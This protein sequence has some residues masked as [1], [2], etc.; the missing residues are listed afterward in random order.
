MTVIKIAKNNTVCIQSRQCE[1]KYQASINELRILL[2][3][4][5]INENID[6]R[7]ENMYT[8]LMNINKYVHKT[9]YVIYN[10]FIKQIFLSCVLKIDYDSVTDL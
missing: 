10:L 8:Y 6:K 2:R 7:I 3:V 9:I 4:S 1:Q 5:K